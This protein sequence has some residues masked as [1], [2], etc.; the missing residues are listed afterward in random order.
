[1]LIS[2]FDNYTLISSTAGRKT[3]ALPVTPPQAKKVAA[4]RAG[5]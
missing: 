1:M 2:I 3:T 4:P 5:E